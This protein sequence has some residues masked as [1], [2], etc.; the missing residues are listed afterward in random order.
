MSTLKNCYFIN[1]CV[2]LF[3]TLSVAVVAVFPWIKFIKR[4]DFYYFPALVTLILAPEFF[5]PIRDFF[6]VIITQP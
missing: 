5:L 2:R 4:H 1:L 6:Q 3:T